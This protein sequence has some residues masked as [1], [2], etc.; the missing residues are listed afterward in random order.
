MLSL[1]HFRQIA[2]VGFGRNRK[3]SHFLKKTIDALCFKNEA[4]GQAHHMF[5]RF[6]NL[7][8]YKKFSRNFLCFIFVQGRSL[9]F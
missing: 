1:F 3:D 2:D 7:R 6:L 8:I 9:V 5:S 4:L